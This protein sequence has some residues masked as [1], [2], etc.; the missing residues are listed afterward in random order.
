MAEDGGE[1]HAAP[2]VS[3]PCPTALGIGPAGAVAT[4]RAPPLVAAA[5]SSSFRPARPPA[6]GVCSDWALVF[7]GVAMCVLAGFRGRCLRVTRRFTAA[8]H[9]PCRCKRQP[10]CCRPRG[11]IIRAHPSPYPHP[12]ACPSSPTS[13]TS[14]CSP[15]S[16]S[17]QPP[18]QPGCVTAALARGS[19][20][21]AARR[22]GRAP[23][24]PLA[25]R[26]LP[27]PC[28]PGAALHLHSNACHPHLP[29]LTRASAHA[30]PPACSSWWRR[31]SSVPAA[32]G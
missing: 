27:P 15:S 23:S 31:A 10:S 30:H 20:H 26:P 24:P 28:L 5:C 29:A 12:G 16:R 13:A 4:C 18:S 19:K 14:A 22:E 6:P 25:S 2:A 11:L 1:E 7:G 17:S 21:A 3:R 9:L 8:L 32:P